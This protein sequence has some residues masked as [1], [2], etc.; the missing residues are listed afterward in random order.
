MTRPRYRALADRLRADILAGHYPVGSRLPSEQQLCECFAVSRHTV[1]EA[2]RSL[3]TDG[4][5]RSRQGAGTEVVAGQVGSEYRQSLQSLD[6]ILQYA[7]QTRLEL[8][9][10]RTVKPG[11]RLAA[12]LG[13]P[14]GQ[15]WRRF[16]GVRVEAGQ[17]LVL[18]AT[19][20]Y[21]HPEFA[22][23][24]LQSEAVYRQLERRYGLAIAE[25][26]QEI[27]AV[28]LEPRI[29]RLLSDEPGAPGLRIVRRY[30]FQGHGML[31]IAVSH[32]PADRFAYTS[33]LVAV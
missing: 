28:S 2:L 15:S 32:H 6:D 17:P 20:V 12:L 4:L 24:G 27:T 7:A 25:V 22:E 19:D 26:E 10:P 13:V 3:G 5:V 29:A 16:R 23:I 33:R 21:L 8:E 1:R 18:C 11:A 30:H 31:E 14:A 9:R